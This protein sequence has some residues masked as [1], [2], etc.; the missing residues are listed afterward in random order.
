MHLH[1]VFVTYSETVSS[2][3][4]KLISILVKHIKRAKNWILRQYQYYYQCIANIFT[5]YFKQPIKGKHNFVHSL[6]PCFL[7][8]ETLPLPT[9]GMAWSSTLHTPHCELNFAQAE[10]PNARSFERIWMRTCFSPR[11]VSGLLFLAKGQGTSKVVSITFISCDLTG[12]FASTESN[13]KRRK[14]VFLFHD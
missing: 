4:S 13:F 10:W 12:P 3:Q 1:T 14:G 2:L 5:H 6:A 7:P 11:W 8:S 9:L